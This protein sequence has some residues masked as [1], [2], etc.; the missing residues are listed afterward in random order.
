MSLPIRTVEDVLLALRPIRAAPDSPT[1]IAA[2]HLL[3]QYGG[4]I[5]DLIL[6]AGEVERL[7]K[8]DRSE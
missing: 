2:Y 6:L 4:W 5:D 1:G 3:Q 8:F 7:R